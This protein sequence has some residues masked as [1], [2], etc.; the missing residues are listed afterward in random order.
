MVGATVP[1]GDKAVSLK[2][3]CCAAIATLV[4]APHPPALTN[5]CLVTSRFSQL[6]DF[7]EHVLGVPAQRTGTQYAEF[8]TGSAVLAI[9]D[10][11]AQEAYIP[12][13]TQPEHNA[14][15][16]VEFRVDDVD[17]EFTRL[18]TIVHVWVK[19]PAV[20]PWHTR[21][22]YFRDPDGN[23]VDFFSAAAK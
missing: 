23:L 19:R 13:S 14:S 12:G 9:F 21:S 22:F 3:A 7:Y 6:V 11:A 18:Q 20:T 1:V 16:I 8:H 5:T 4:V 15:S 2:F 17:A 10:Q